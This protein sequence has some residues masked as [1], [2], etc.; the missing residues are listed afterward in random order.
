MQKGNPIR[1]RTPNSGNIDK[2]VFWIA[3]PIL[4]LLSLTLLVFSEQSGEIVQKLFYG[5]MQNLGFLYSL[6]G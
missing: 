1:S 2:P 3:V 4:F 6:C 5:T